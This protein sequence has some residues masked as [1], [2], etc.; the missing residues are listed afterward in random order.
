LSVLA[1]TEPRWE[2]LVIDDGSTD[3]T[4][5]V[6]KTFGDPRI[7]LVR[8]N[9]R[10]IMHLADSYNDA[11]AM[12]R[13]EFVAVLEGDDFWPPWKL[14]RQL[15]SFHDPAVVLSWGRAAETDTDG[16]VMRLIPR[17]RAVAR[18]ARASRG[19]TMRALLEG[20]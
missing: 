19:A 7:S 12:A 6:V 18:M 5:D 16:R 4:D 15:R 17:R 2:Q 1:Q 3:G 14:T 9:H 13:G 20:T 10:G 11:L 8:R